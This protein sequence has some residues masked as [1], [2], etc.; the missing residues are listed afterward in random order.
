MDTISHTHVEIL[1]SLLK[2][3]AGEKEW[4]RMA[5]TVDRNVDYYNRFKDHFDNI[6]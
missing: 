4:N 2:L 6:Y 1:K 5:R 3:S